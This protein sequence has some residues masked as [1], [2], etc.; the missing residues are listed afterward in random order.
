MKGL[1]TLLVLSALLL[2]GSCNRS[3]TS[4]AKATSAN[5]LTIRNDTDYDMSL[6][7]KVHDVNFPEC[8]D[9]SGPT[10]VSHAHT[11]LSFNSPADFD[12]LG[13]YGYIN[14][15]LDSNVQWTAPGDW[16]FIKLGFDG[17]PAW[18]NIGT[19]LCVSQS[20]Y[21]WTA[22]NITVHLAWTSVAGGYE[23]RAYY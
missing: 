9:M 15:Q 12:A 14:G 17:F 11:V 6:D 13:W 8:G 16:D 7:F 5:S 23:V 18:C 3:E 20:Y 1:S 22:N 2:T 21:Q 10:R 19:G 4:L